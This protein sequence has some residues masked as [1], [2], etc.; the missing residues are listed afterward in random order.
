MVA[1]CKCYRFEIVHE[2]SQWV[3]S[4]L[5]CSG[6]GKGETVIHMLMN[7]LRFAKWPQ[8]V[9]TLCRGVVQG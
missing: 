2:K 6:P 1:C 4:V 8:F 7:H 5:R 9:H 3:C